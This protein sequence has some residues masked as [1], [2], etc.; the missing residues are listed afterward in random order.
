MISDQITPLVKKAK[1]LR[2]QAYYKYIYGFDI[3]RYDLGIDPLSRI[4]IDPY[5]IQRF[6]G[7]VGRD[8]TL[9]VRS[10]IGRVQKGDW[11]RKSGM[12]IAPHVPEC[13]SKVLFAEQFDETGLYRSFERHFI[14]GVAW[15]ETEFYRAFAEV[16]AM[17]YTWHNVESEDDLDDRFREIDA[18]YQSMAKN[19]YQTQGELKSYSAILREL[20]KEV[21]IDRSRTGEPLFVCGRH[22]LAIAK[23]LD[24]DAI[25]VVVAVRHHKFA[26]SN[27]NTVENNTN[28]LL[29]T[30]LR[31]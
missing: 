12:N 28:T 21:V 5:Q 30:V 2:S 18:I 20:S 22:R 31:G 23:I 4:W 16:V 11:D 14:D 17:D 15:P 27:T 1:Y 9:S 13:L 29:S 7:R 8:N 24:L 10:D 19:G 25:P 26:E 3:D 6:T